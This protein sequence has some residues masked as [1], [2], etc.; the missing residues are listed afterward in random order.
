MNMRRNLMNLGVA[1]LM[2]VAIAGTANASTQGS[3]GTTSTGSVSISASIPSRV[4][5]SGLSD[6]AFTNVDPSVNAANAQNVCVWSNTGTK[7]YRLTAT[8]SGASNAFTL[9]NASLTVPYTVE[10][11]GA[12]GQ[13]SGTALAAGSALTGLTSTATNSSCASGPA[14]SASLIVKIGASDLQTM[15][16]STSYTG[17]L[18]LLVAPE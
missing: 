17:T 12:S 8:G 2:T 10:W 4:R 14:A 11:S 15:D 9:A 1:T 3:L 16:A 18:T 6:V 7:G 5:I 13:T